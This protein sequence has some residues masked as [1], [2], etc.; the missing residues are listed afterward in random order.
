MNQLNIHFL[1]DKE[2]MSEKINKFITILFLF[3]KKL[4][5]FIRY[6]M[7]QCRGKI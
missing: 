7:T 4:R 2:C 3:T 5:S 6:T 1:E